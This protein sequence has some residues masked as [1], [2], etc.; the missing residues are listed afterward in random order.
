MAEFTPVMPVG[1][2]HR[3]EAYVIHAALYR[4]VLFHFNA[5]ARTEIFT[6]LRR[7]PVRS[8]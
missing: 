2:W 5:E 6:T 1:E 8:G 3:I 7:S 4:P